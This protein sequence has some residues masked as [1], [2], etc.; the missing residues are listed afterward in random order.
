MLLLH[1]TNGGH[2]VTLRFKKTRNFTV[3]HNAMLDDP[4][5]SFRAKGVLA[6]LLSKPDN[7]SVRSVQ[8]SEVCKGKYGEGREAV[9]NAINEIEA[10]GYCRRIKSQDEK[11]RWI[12]VCEL[13]EEP[14]F[15]TG[16]GIPSV[17]TPPR[18]ENPTSVDRALLQELSPNTNTASSTLGSE[19][20]KKGKPPPN[21]LHTPYRLWFT[22]EFL[23]KFG[24]TYAFLPRNGKDINTILAACQNDKELAKGATLAFFRDDRDFVKGHS[25]S[26]LAGEIHRYIEEERRKP[27]SAKLVLDDIANPNSPNYQPVRMN[28]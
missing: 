4:N 17:S 21:P 24:F 16:D 7:W 27:S 11:G 23:N 6:Y 26:R 5:M 1:G 8:L 9:R 15:P 10:A 2:G 3:L 14:I 20:V 28:R 19:K 13:A 22:Q 12:T 18:P 25:L